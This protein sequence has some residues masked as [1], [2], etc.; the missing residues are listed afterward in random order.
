MTSFASWH[1]K[2]HNLKYFFT[3]SFFFLFSTP[4]AGGA[5]QIQNYVEKICSLNCFF[6]IFEV[7]SFEPSKEPVS[8]RGQQQAGSQTGSGRLSISGMYRQEEVLFL[9]SLSLSQ[10]FFGIRSLSGMLSLVALSSSGS[11]S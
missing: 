2:T 11:R 1:T 6:G 5:G 9:P 4:H 7:E 3:A 8:I 10:V